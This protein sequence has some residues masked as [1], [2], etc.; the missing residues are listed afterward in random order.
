MKI[1]LTLASPLEEGVDGNNKP[2][3]KSIRAELVAFF[4]NYFE[5]VTLLSLRGFIWQK[6][7]L[8][9]RKQLMI[10]YTM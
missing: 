7:N 6:I 10:K 9:T 8:I 1:S 5:T 3:T 4:Y 2:P